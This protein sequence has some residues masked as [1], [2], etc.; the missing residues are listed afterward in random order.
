MDV[1]PLED[2]IVVELGV[3]WQAELPPMLDQALNHELGRDALPARPGCNQAAMERDAVED[4]DLGSAADDQTLDEIEAVK[5]P[6]PAGHLREIPAR[7]R[8]RPSNP[9]PSVQHAPTAEDAVDGPL[10]RQRFDP[11]GSEGLEDRLGPEEAQVTVGPQTAPHFKD[12]VFESG[13][14]PLG[15]VGDWR[16]TGPIDPVEA[17]AVRMADPAIHRGGTHVEVAG[18]LLLRP[19]PSNGLNYRPTAA[20]LPVSLL[21]VNSSQ[22]VSFPTSLH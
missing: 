5:F 20:G 7:R 9:M 17:L 10:R 11:A 13:L 22:G 1:R 6:V 15:G 19:S 2:R 16:A 18:D 4:L 14:G 21:M 3:A 12:Q 8:G